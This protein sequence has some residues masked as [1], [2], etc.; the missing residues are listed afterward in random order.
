MTTQPEVPR[1]ADRI[2]SRRR[3]ISGDAVVGFATLGCL[4]A[5]VAGIFKALAERGL[6]AGVC[7]LAGVVAFA[8]VL[9]VYFRKE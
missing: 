2:G 4:V 7:L 1:P 6:G 5:G 9:Y 8:T 3:S